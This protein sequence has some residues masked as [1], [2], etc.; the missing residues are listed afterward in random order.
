MF[1]ADKVKPIVIAIDTIVNMKTIHVNESGLNDTH[2][3]IGA[4]GE[5]NVP[6]AEIPATIK[7]KQIGAAIPAEAA[8]RRSAAHGRMELESLTVNHARAFD[9]DIGGIDGKEQSPIAIL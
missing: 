2:A 4:L 1:T 5:A 9:G 7:Q 8:R 6:E 3:V